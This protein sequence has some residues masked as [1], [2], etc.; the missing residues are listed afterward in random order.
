[1]SATA[2]KNGDG[3]DEEEDVDGMTRLVTASHVGATSI[4]SV[5]AILDVRVHARALG[6]V[7]DGKRIEKSGK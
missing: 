5:V 1:M 3:E 2:G 4:E 6:V 7:L